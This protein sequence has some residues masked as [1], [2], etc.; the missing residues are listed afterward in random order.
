ME[1]KIGTVL[2]TKVKRIM[3]ELKIFV[4]KVKRMMMEVK[5]FVTKV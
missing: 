1:V 5:I 2:I 3:T 4:T